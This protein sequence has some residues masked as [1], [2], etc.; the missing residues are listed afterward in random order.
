MNIGIDIESIDKDFNF[1]AAYKRNYC[2]LLNISI[3]PKELLYSFKV[4]NVE[5][6]IGYPETV[7]YI[8]YRE[9]QNKKW[10]ELKLPDQKQ[11]LYWSSVAI[12][13]QWFREHIA[14]FG[15][16]SLTRERAHQVAFI[17]I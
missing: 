15:L 17:A 13:N 6:S 9:W 7:Y 12:G 4:N 3:V 5:Q 10:F 16:E 2:T 11:D 1:G 14:D 8:A